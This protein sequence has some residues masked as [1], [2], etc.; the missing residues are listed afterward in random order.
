[1]SPKSR[2]GEKGSSKLNKRKYRVAVIA[3]KRVLGGPAKKVR[4]M[5]KTRTEVEKMK[6]LLPVGEEMGTKS[7]NLMWR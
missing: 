4:V 5:G 3:P 6:L 1:V 7:Q 2:K